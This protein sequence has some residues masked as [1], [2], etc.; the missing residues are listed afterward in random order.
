M[1][2]KWVK[3]NKNSINTSIS[4]VI[5]SYLT[6]VYK[7][8]RWRYE[9]LFGYSLSDFDKAEKT[10]FVMWHNRLALA[11]YAFQKHKNIHALV[12]PHSDGRIIGNILKYFGYQIIEGSTNRSPVA[13]MRQIIRHLSNGDN[14]AITPDG[15][16]GPVY[17][18]NSNLVGIAKI[19]KAKIVPISFNVTSYFRFKSW[20]RLIMPLPFGRGTVIVGEPIYSFD[21]EEFINAQ[22]EKTLN[23][24][25]S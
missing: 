4:W 12:S 3:D 7:T 2:K 22:L 19:A 11:P 16:R 8:I 15:P 1:I 18:I 23:Q 17:K 13:A 25:S 5:K 9:M 10:I 14:I 6:L 21:N 20:D 24:L